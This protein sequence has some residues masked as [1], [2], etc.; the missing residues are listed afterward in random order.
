MSDI[1]IYDPEGK[2]EHCM[3][4]GHR[5]EVVYLKGSPDGHIL[6]IHCPYCNG[7]GKASE[8]NEPHPVS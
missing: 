4:S 6:T 1:K 7:T 3:G 8:E 5:I 2:C